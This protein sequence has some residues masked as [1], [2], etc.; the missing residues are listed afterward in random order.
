MVTRLTHFW[1][2]HKTHH[3]E[4]VN[5]ALGNSD[6]EEVSKS[7]DNCWLHL[8]KTTE[9]MWA[10][11]SHSCSTLRKSAETAAT[12]A[13]DCW[14]HLFHPVRTDFNV[15]THRM[16]EKFPQGS[17]F[18]PFLSTQ[19]TTHWRFLLIDWSNATPG[20]PFDVND[21]LFREEQ[22]TSCILVSQ[23]N[24]WSVITVPVRR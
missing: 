20:G 10:C 22:A 3:Y 8:G 5:D 19:R 4:G 7:L 1:G 18:V 21:H 9:R 13:A 15:T 11:E 12:R 17:T 23:T 2:F 24:E 14:M 6:Q 16:V